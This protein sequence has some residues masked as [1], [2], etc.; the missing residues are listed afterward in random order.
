MEYYLLIPF[1]PL[2]AF[3]LNILL[4]KEVF[5]EK[6]H[7]VSILAVVGSFII[8]VAT[9][10]DVISGKTLNEDLY[11]WIV[12]GTFKAS[13]G[14]LIDPLTAVM[15]IV[16]TTCSS[17][18]QIYSIG[19]MHG[20]KG[21]YRFFAYMSLFTFCMLMLAMSNN[22]LQLYFGWEGVGLCSYFLIGY[23]FHKKSASDAGKKA[24][25][26]NRFGDFGFSLGVII[27]FLTF[28][29]LHYLPVFNNMTGIV[30]KTVHLLG[31]DVSLVTLIALLLFCGAVGKSAQ[32]PLHVWLP[33]AMEGPTPVSA[34]IHAA[35]MV[36]A[37]VFLVARCSPIFNLSEVALIVVAL[38]G[39]IT[40]LFAATIALVQKDIKRI[41]AYS[42][43]SQLGYMFLGCGVGAYA[44]G[45]FHLYTHAFF[46]AL[47]FLCAGSVMH[48]MGGELNIQKMGGLKKYMPVTYLTFVLGSLSISGIPGFAGFFSK[49]EILWLAYSSPNPVG[50]F[51]WLLGTIAA[52]LTA[53]YSFRLIFLTF[54]GKFRGTHEQEHH[55]HESPKVMTIPLILLSIGAIAAGWVGI[56]HLLG[57]GAHFAEFL[58]SVLGHPEAHGTHNEEWMV[59]GISV[60]V[61]LSGIG[62]A[63]YMYLARTDI[64]VRLAKN[65][66]SIYRTLFNKYYVDE[67]YSFTIVR[68]TLWTAK[69]IL[70]G[71]TDAKIIE[72][73]V[74]GVPRLIGKFSGMLRKVQTGLVH[75]YATII[76][77]GAFFIIALAILLR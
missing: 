55:L 40:A 56:P 37:G 22:F 43:I 74:N 9:L 10:F 1:L 13:V 5:R 26:V 41:I 19:Y 62:L 18:I 31:F 72:G 61:G 45:I 64:P 33:D 32:I 66:S 65:F 38:T 21:Y 39:A 25:I 11:T 24:F 20:D 71:F 68:P 73:I 30:G 7:W 63:A 2:A 77:A 8:A 15:L 57:G 76:A 46:K 17:L 60:I 35:T 29:T 75:H 27:V 54:H 53:F 16:V 58:K 34:L 48:A 59:M 36:T 51:V 49:D 44:A 14:F 3:I 52:F 70:I 69:N 47:L 6:A 28:G 67:L 12:S 50:K 4:G 42:T 23:Y